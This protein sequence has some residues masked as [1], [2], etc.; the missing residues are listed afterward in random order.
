MGISRSVGCSDSAK[1]TARVNFPVALATQLA[2]CFA[3]AES[4]PVTPAIPAISN[5]DR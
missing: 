4:L 3:I 2:S 5:I 1:T